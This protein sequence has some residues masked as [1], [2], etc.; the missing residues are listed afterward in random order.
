VTRQGL[1]AAAGGGWLR[2]NAFGG[3]W[4]RR[5]SIFPIQ[6]R[7]GAGACAWKGKRVLGTEFL[8]SS[9]PRYIHQLTDEYT[10][11]YICRLTDEC[12]GPMFVGFK[13]KEYILFIFLGNEEYILFS[14]SVCNGIQIPLN[15]LAESTTSNGHDVTYMYLD[16]TLIYT[17]H[18]LN[19]KMKQ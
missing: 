15:K 16:T 7:S 14:Y 1:W 4:Q 9:S 8:P 13:P 2:S 17:L 11:T 18:C 5:G 6:V 12:T 19:I 3:R 10:A